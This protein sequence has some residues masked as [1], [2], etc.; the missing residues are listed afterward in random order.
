MIAYA[1]LVNRTR[2]SQKEVVQAPPIAYLFIPASE[3]LISKI[4]QHMR[5]G[6]MDDEDNRIIVE[7]VVCTS[8]K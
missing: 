1:E 2:R 8:K 4:H 6:R 5:F 7:I 3:G